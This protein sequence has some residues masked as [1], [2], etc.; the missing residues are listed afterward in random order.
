MSEIRLG[1]L[2][3]EVCLRRSPESRKRSWP[4]SRPEPAGGQSGLETADDLLR[5]NVFASLTPF[6]RMC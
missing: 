3:G 1:R 2:R 4:A 6:P 5:A